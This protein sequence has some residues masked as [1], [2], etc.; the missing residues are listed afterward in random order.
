MEA[1]SF[2]IT[3]ELIQA[4]ISM[5]EYA[6]SIRNSS[7]S[8]LN[9]CGYHAAQAIEK[10]LKYALYHINPEMCERL[11]YT[12]SIDA[13][14]C[15]LERVQNGFISTHQ[16]VADMSDLLSLLNKAR[17]GDYT[18]TQGVACKVLHIAQELS[19]EI[20]H[21]FGLPVTLVSNEQ[22]CTNTQYITQ[23][24]DL[25][26]K[27]MHERQTIA[28]PNGYACPADG[29]LISSIK[30]G[31]RNVSVELTMLSRSKAEKE[32]FTDGD[33]CTF[34]VS[35]GKVYDKRQWN[36]LQRKLANRKHERE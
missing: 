2:D 21:A 26:E 14:L 13:A 31:I 8:L 5:A 15:K 18:V 3:P 29:Y 23:A 22:Y 30:Q 27:E 16:D 19:E 10:S 6:Y 28:T 35:Y 33:K 1:Y 9:M 32:R 20:I 11:G 7:P 4:D 34:Y 25:I 24:L 17:Y 12:H 36:A